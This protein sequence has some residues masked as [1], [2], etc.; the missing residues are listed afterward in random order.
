MEHKLLEHKLVS[1]IVDVNRTFFKQNRHGQML[2]RWLL[3]SRNEHKLLEHALFP[4]ILDV[5]RTFFKTN[6][7]KMKMFTKWVAMRPKWTS[8]IPKC[9]FFRD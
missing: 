5:N 6:H 8:P 3:R 2:L 1:L 9:V 4:L 7:Q